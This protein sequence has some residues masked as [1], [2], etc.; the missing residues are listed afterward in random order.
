MKYV[1]LLAASLLFLAP[2]TAKADELVIV[3]PR[4]R[5]VIVERPRPR[6]VV[7]VAPCRPIRI[8]RPIRLCR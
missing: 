1:M 7:L 3:R 6:P 2:A 8:V 5:I 4:H